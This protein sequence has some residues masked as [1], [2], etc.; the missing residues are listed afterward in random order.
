MVARRRT[1]EILI[2][3]DDPGFRETLKLVLEPYFHT[4]EAE[5]GE[6][7]IE[8]VERR[9][10]DLALF[11]MHMHVLTGLEALRIIRERHVI[12]PCILITADATDALRRDAVE[13]YSVLQKPVS[14]SELVQTVSTALAKAYDEG[15]PLW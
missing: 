10:V 1:Y 6:E 3:D 9:P 2:A 14:K 8:I 12:L 4:V 13:A 7:A 15:S 5:S 11:D